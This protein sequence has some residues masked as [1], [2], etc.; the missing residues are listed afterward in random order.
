LPPT[1]SDVVRK[2]RDASTG[3][4]WS[5]RRRGPRCR[6]LRGASLV[7]EKTAPAWTDVEAIS[8]ARWHE[9]LERSA[10]T[11]R[12][13]RA[14]AHRNTGSA[15]PR[16]RRPSAVEWFRSVDTPNRLAEPGRRS[17]CSRWRRSSSRDQ[18]GSACSAG[19]RRRRRSRRPRSGCHSGRVRHSLWPRSAAS[20]A[21]ARYTAACY[22]SYFVGQTSNHGMSRTSS[23]EPIELAQRAIS[24]PPTNCGASA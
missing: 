24:P 11:G 5:R 14:L 17:P 8:T 15:G 2:V 10:C 13:S 7:F 19:R 9:L 23:H 16:P 22:T 6:W 20:A 1:E 21:S 3:F 12:R 4:R 18:P